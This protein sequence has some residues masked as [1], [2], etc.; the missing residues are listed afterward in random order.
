MA[1]TLRW[2]I[3]GTG[4]IAHSFT[5]D[6]AHIEEGIAV[7]VGSRSLDSANSFADEFDIPRRYGS[8][9]ELVSDPEVDAVYVGTPHPMHRDHVILALEH[10]KHVL[11]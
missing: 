7:A 10:G 5:G 9:E 1:K 4:G 8:Y 3:I 2:G 11:C 6:L